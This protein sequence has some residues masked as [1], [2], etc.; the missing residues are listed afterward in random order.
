M[1]VASS[2]ARA[3]FE[4]MSKDPAKEAIYIKNVHASLQKRGHTKLAL[5][6][7]NEYHKLEV[8]QERSVHHSK[9]TPEKE[10][11]RVLLGLYKKL[12]AK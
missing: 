5:A 1:T 3:L 4:L 2:Y 9:V 12:V 7:A 6:I 10:R 11:V 8:Q